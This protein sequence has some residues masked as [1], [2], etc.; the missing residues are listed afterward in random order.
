M[1]SKPPLQLTSVQNPRV[2]QVVKL[3]EHKQRRNTGLFI[4]DGSRQV[5][6]AIAADLTAVELFYLP[7]AIDES[8]VPAGCQLI[9][10]NQPVMEKLAYRNNPEG[11]IGVFEQRHWNWQDVLGEDAAGGLWLVMV[12][13]EKPGNIGA[14]LRTADAAGCR[15]VVIADAVADVY[16]PNAIHA[17]TGTVFT[18]PLVS[19]DGQTVRQHFQDRQVQLVIATPS[20]NTLWKEVDLC[21]PTAIIIGPEDTGLDESWLSLAGPLA[22]PVRVPMLGRTADSL[23]ASVTAAVL[24][25]ETVRQRG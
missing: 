12:G 5:Q 19:D 3:R 24:L 2:K 7:G 9:E 11:V 22:C 6:R 25:F 17:S 16:N 20:A 13:I 10:V 1:P 21:R 14:M 23:N 15:G 18:M 4:A 8:S